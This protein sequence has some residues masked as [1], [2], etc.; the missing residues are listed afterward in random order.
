VLKLTNYAD[1]L[2]HLIICLVL[3]VI[4]DG[5]LTKFLVSSGLGI[6]ANPFLHTIVAERKFMLIKIGGVLLVSLLLLDI[7][8]LKPTVAVISS[9]TAVA[10]YTAIVYWNISIFIVSQV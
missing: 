3:L 7:N 2:K 1:N 8:R 6:E 5:L 10:F 9:A 4:A